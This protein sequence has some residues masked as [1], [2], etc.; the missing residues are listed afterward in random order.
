[1]KIDI[2]NKSYDYQ[3]ECLLEMTK[4]D[5]GI[6]CLPTGTGK[7]Y[8]QASYIAQSI[9]D[10]NGKFGIY[11]INAPRIMLS[12][13]LL[14]EV[15]IILTTNNIDAR[16][17]TVHSG[18]DLDKKDLE[19][20]RYNTNKKFGYDIKYADIGSSTSIDSIKVM[21]EKAK[22]ENIPI[23]LLS[24]YNSA[25][26]I[27]KGCIG[28]GDINLIMNDEAHFLTNLNFHDILKVL[29]AKKTFF[30]T[31][32]T[33]NSCSDKG[34][35][36]NNKEKYG[37]IIYK[38]S[39]REAIDKGRMVRPRI[40]YIIHSNIEQYKN[41]DLE[42]S[43][44]RVIKEC[45]EHHAKVLNGVKPKV[46][47]TVNGVKTITKFLASDEYINM[48][49]SGIT[50]YAI[51]SND[52]VSNNING[53]R[54]TRSQFLKQLKEDG[55]DKNKSILVLHFDILAEGIDVSG[56]TGILPFK[57]LPKSKF[58]QTFGRAARLDAT[59]RINIENNKILP[60]ELEK[61]IKPYA[62]IL[63]PSILEE[64][65]DNVIRLE[66]LIW[67][68]RDFGFNP[69]EDITITMESKGGLE[70]KEGL[71]G[72]NEILKRD[73][74]LGEIIEN[75]KSE[76]EDENIANLSLSGYANELGLI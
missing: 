74:Y 45:L 9:L 59:D 14:K 12:Y 20:I 44:P 50:I 37:D 27:K 66:T 51:S 18:R 28:Y 38:M 55:L 60:N 29:K 75:I 62:W 7:T 67:E 8:I 10:N 1:M 49:T 22:T 30:F 23:V 5:L 6:I 72:L 33:K 35:G 21:M 56:F 39:P 41:E 13:Q 73:S 70:V 11:V 47:V 40:Q 71:E 53:I 76:Y 24:T 65:I 19:N 32:T 4:H 16:Y 26:K 46:L 43:F 42:K 61:F 36:M 34:L 17:M 64:D 3:R 52:K 58:L 2:L 25:K 68:L 48:I 57:E 63:V 31:A 69:V 54:V 15:F